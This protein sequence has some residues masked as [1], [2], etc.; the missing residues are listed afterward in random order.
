MQRFVANVWYRVRVIVDTNAGT[1]D[2]FVDGVR[3]ANAQPLR[4]AAS[5]VTQ[6]RYYVDGA[7]A[8]IPKQTT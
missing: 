6:L 7:N 2:L 3:M 5:A 8:V 1:F 4:Q